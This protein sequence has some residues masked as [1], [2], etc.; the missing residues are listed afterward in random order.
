M[1]VFSDCN[2]KEMSVFLTK[3]WVVHLTAVG[4]GL[5]RISQPRPKQLGIASWP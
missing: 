5:V 4:P 1:H 3:Y 2:M